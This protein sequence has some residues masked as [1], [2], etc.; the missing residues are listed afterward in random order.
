MPIF[1]PSTNWEGM[2]EKIEKLDYDKSMVSSALRLAPEDAAKFR[3]M[4]I[5]PG[6]GNGPG[7][8]EFR[9]HISN[10]SDSP[11]AQW[12]EFMDM[13]R[14]DPK[15][16]YGQFSRTIAVD[17]VTI[18]I[19]KGEQSL[20]I[21][22]LNSLAEMTKPYYKSGTGF[23]GV[24]CIMEIGNFIKEYGIMTDLNI[25]ISNESSWYDGVPIYIQA[26]LNFR[27][28]GEKKPQY[29]QSGTGMWGKKSFGLGSS[30]G[31]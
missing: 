30:K 5:I 28:I 20:W 2:Q 15:F 1:P 17:F 7:P 26:S 14:G 25:S 21:D 22:A 13:G 4:P 6:G 12:N 24:L 16:M 29:Q 27:V 18:A 3:F 23:N 8:I 31:L 10:I 9:A 11:A 19:K